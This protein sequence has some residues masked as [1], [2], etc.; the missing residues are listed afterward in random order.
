MNLDEEA[1][2]ITELLAGKVIESCIRNEEG[3]LLIKFKCGARIFV[4]SE[5]KLEFSITGC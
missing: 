4:N 5:K 1:E 3:E 2:K